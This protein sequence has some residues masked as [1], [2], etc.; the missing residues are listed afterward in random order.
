VQSWRQSTANPPSPRRSGACVVVGAAIFE[1]WGECRATGAAWRWC[2]ASPR[3]GGRSRRQVA[4]QFLCF[5]NDHKL[6]ASAFVRIT[7]RTGRRIE[8]PIS[9]V[10]SE[11]KTNGIWIASKASVQWKSAGRFEAFARCNLQYSADA[12]N[13]PRAIKVQMIVRFGMVTADDLKVVPFHSPSNRK[14]ARL[15]RRGVGL[16][17][18]RRR[19]E[20]KNDRPGADRRGGLAGGLSRS[21][22]AAFSQ[23]TGSPPGPIPR[24]PPR[25]GPSP[26]QAAP[27]PSRRSV[28]AVGR[29]FVP[30][31]RG[32]GGPFQTAPG[33]RAPTDWPGE[34]RPPAAPAGSKATAVTFPATAFLRVRVI[35]AGFGGNSNRLATNHFWRRRMPGRLAVDSRQRGGT[36]PAFSNLC[37]RP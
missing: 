1:G 25:L 27:F 18:G 9:G 24:L 23:K 17:S 2:R 19:K 28:C 26:D 16:I 4:V 7:N 35:S 32:G 5:T 34:G 30:G 36:E 13:I 12:P 21:R 3:G 10:F 6:G 37:K 33:S 8:F 15:R 22:K 29:G 31:S 20:R 14:H 11:T